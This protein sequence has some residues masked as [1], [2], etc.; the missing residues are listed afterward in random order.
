MTPP[1]EFAARVTAAGVPCVADGQNIR[2]HGEIIAKYWSD[3]IDAG[4]KFLPDHAE[5]VAHLVATE[6]EREKWRR[7][8]EQRKAEASAASRLASDI[9]AINPA[10]Q[11]EV[12]GDRVRVTI[13]GLTVEQARRVLQASK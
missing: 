3:G 9:R 7:K 11:V 13:A 12:T 5:A 8:L 2:S 1:E 4:G 6:P 10:A